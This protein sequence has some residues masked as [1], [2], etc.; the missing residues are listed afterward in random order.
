[1]LQIVNWIICNNIKVGKV[2]SVKYKI[3]ITLS[4]VIKIIGAAVVII[5]LYGLHTSEDYHKLLPPIVRYINFSLTYVFLFSFI[6]LW[7]S[8]RGNSVQNTNVNLQKLQPNNDLPQ[9]A[10]LTRQYVIFYV[11]NI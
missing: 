1:M 2:G 5:F 8:W 6:F 3:S 7:K 9:K 11:I 10:N 4:V